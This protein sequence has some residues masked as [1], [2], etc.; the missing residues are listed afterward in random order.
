[1]PFI[2]AAMFAGL[3][4]LP[5]LAQN[6]PEATTT[7]V[8]GTVERLD[9]RTLML[10]SRDGQ[11]LTIALPPS[12]TVFG[13][14]KTSVDDVLTGDYVTAIG[15]DSRGGKMLAV[16]VYVYPESLHGLREGRA[17]ANNRPGS[18]TTNGTVGSIIKATDGQIL[19]LNV[20]G[21]GADYTVGSEVPVFTCVP[22][23][24]AL[25]K[26]GAA[27]YATA[28]KEPDGGF[29]ASQLIAEKDGIKPPF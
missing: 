20:R 8:R 15:A 10:K 28:S 9:G 17:L 7:Q 23:D 4:A 25:L 12:F 19:H 18:V 11:E 2:T 3:L 22:G 13:M 6:P 16:E 5:T 26:P 24:A 1:V 14:A 29:T 27:V 21:G